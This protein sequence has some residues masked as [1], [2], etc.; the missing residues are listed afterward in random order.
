MS[1]AR[2]LTTIV[3]TDVVAFGRLTAAD[4]HK[5]GSHARHCIDAS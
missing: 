5:I 2:K 3:V 1:E 4:R